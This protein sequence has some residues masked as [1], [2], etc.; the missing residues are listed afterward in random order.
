VAHEGVGPG[1]DE[2]VGHGGAGKGD[3]G[4][5]FVRPLI[6][7]ADA[8][9]AD[10]GVEGAVGDV[11]PLLNL[12]SR[13]S[14]NVALKITTHSCTNN[15]IDFV[16]LAIRGVYSIFL[17]SRDWALR[18]FD[19]WEGKAFQISLSR[20]QAAT[21]QL[22]LRNK[23]LTEVRVMVQLFSHLIGGKLL[24]TQAFLGAFDKL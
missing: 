12:F 8:I 4:F 17:N 23:F 2:V 18:E 1:E 20:R 9:A 5:R 6:G 19:V 10:D 11:E 21:A 7:E 3:V 22:P 16:E 13:V 14:S 24:G 15:D